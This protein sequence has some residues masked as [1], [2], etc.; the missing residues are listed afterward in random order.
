[1]SAKY[2][3]LLQN[4]K[5]FTSNIHVTFSIKCVLQIL[6]LGNCTSKD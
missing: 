2:Q 3:S 4:I 5:L 6:K 1:M